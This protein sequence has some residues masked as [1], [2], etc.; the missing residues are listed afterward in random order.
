MTCDTS[1]SQ[2]C[3]VAR[4]G[5]NGPCRGRT[6]RLS[7]MLHDGRS[8]TAGL[9]VPYVYRLSCGRHNTPLRSCPCIDGLCGS[10]RMPVPHAFLG[11][12][13]SSAGRDQKECLSTFARCGN[14][15][16]RSR[17]ILCVYRLSCDR[18]HS[19]S[20][21]CPYREALCDSWYRSWFYV[22]RSGSISYPGRD[23]IE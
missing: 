21:S 7:R 3:R 17:M 12:S 9:P 5:R 2:G 4:A 20:G 8:R 16:T 18:P 23:R 14:L 11:A 6:T 13:I 10:C 1:D 19:R 15:R 22:S